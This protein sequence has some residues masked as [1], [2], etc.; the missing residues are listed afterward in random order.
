M[1][2]STTGP[3]S[4]PETSRHGLLIGMLLGLSLGVGLCTAFGLGFWVRGVIDRTTALDE[5]K[6]AR[7]AR[8]Q[9]GG[10]AGA[11]TE[12]AAKEAAAEPGAR[13]A[14]SASIADLSLKLVQGDGD[15]TRNLATERP[16][17]DAP[18]PDPQPPIPAVGP[19]P[20]TTAPPAARAI[21]AAREVAPAPVAPERFALRDPPRQVPR[22]FLLP[23]KPW[24]A[25]ADLAADE[26]AGGDASGAN[27]V[28]VC[29]ANRSL[30]TALTWAKSPAEASEQ[31]RRDG[32]LVFLIHVSGNF[33][34]PGF[35]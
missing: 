14:D 22:P 32:K 10:P 12:P 30:D 29:A 19:A 8:S 26:P 3:P 34:N 15:W 6:S 13:R 16:A 27:A 35:T 1:G 20:A 25:V 7:S 4:G 9:A 11:A 31:A 33:E 23:D 17:A 18:P 21:L 2:H 28:Q 24:F 5:G